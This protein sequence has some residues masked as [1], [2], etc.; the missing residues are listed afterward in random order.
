MKT[1]SIPKTRVELEQ[2]LKD[3]CYGYGL[4]YYNVNEKN[5]VY[6]GYSIDYANGVYIWCFYDRSESEKIK[7][8]R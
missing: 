4:Y 1:D 7:S 3:N 6:E 8:F 5:P 2:W